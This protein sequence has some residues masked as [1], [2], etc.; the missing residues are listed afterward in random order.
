[1]LKMISGIIAWSANSIT[2]C[3]AMPSPTVVPQAPRMREL[4]MEMTMRIST[5]G[6]IVSTVLATEKHIPVDIPHEIPS[7]R[8]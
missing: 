8:A 1:M 4:D 3:L 7:P 2:L 6:S 5:D